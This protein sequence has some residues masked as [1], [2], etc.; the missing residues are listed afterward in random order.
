MLVGPA[1]ATPQ[2]A[3]APRDMQKALTIPDRKTLRISMSFRAL[4][5]G[6]TYRPLAHSREFLTADKERS[7]P[8]ITSRRTEWSATES[9]QSAKVG[10]RPHITSNHLAKIDSENTQANDLDV[11][12]SCAPQVGMRVFEKVQQ[13]THPSCSHGDAPLWVVSEFIIAFFWAVM[14]RSVSPMIGLIV[15]CNWPQGRGA[16]SLNFGRIE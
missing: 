14:L 2:K 12:R 11:F 13:L 10:L 7:D 1:D 5:A 3:V 8:L 16:P 6:R 15:V 4:E 9:A